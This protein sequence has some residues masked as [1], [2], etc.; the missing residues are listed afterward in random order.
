M[1]PD[2][3]SINLKEGILRARYRESLTE[4][5]LLEPNWVYKYEIP[6]GPVGAHIPRGHALRLTI[7]SSD[8]PQWDRNMNTG[9]PLFTEDLDRGK[10]SPAV[11]AARRGARFQLSNVD[12]RAAVNGHPGVIID[13]EVS[14]Q[15]RDTSGCGLRLHLAPSPRPILA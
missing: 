3:R 2:G 9:A 15:A 10:S 14:Q 6:L 7:S 11:G 1:H 8:F 5:S 13:D 4:P 12:A